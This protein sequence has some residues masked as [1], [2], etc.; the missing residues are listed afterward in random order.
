MAKGL[1][2]VVMAMV[3]VTTTPEWPAWASSYQGVVIHVGKNADTVE[4]N[5]AQLLSH[6]LTENGPITVRMVTEG[7]GTPH[8]PAALIILLGVPSH[9]GEISAV[10]TKEH[11][12]PLTPLDPGQEGFLLRSFSQGHE[13]AVLAAGIDDRGVVY[14]VGEILRQAV[15]NGDSVEFPANVAM[16]TAPAF[17]VRGTQIGQSSVMLNKA[18]ARQWTQ[19]EHNHAMADI[20]LAGANTIAVSE[21]TGRVR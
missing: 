12:P 9:H 10:F 11:I 1:G 16:R 4:R 3:I 15:F 18:K 21:G 13:M 14:A 2:T 19:A 6:R 17:E 8:E 7:D 5:A 20:I